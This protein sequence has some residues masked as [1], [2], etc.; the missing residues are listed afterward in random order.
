LPA[1]DFIDMLDLGDATTRLHW[2]EYDHA[3]ALLAAVIDR[4]PDGV[5]AAEAIYWRGIATYLKT[6]SN[7]EMY[8][9]WQEFQPAGLAFC[10]V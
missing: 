7:E 4:Q 9:V 8:R 5:F 10:R 1:D 2:A 6:H 3:I